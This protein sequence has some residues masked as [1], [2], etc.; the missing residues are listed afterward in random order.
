M[1]LF[2]YIPIQSSSDCVACQ[3]GKYT[4]NE[5]LSE[6]TNCEQG[7]YQ[8][9]QGSSGCDNC[10]KGYYQFALGARCVR[11]CLFICCICLCNSYRV[12]DGVLYVFACRC[13]R[14]VAF[15]TVCKLVRDLPMKYCSSCASCE[16]GKF[17]ANEGLANCTSCEAGRHQP[18]QASS[19]CINC[20]QGYYQFASGAR[21]VMSTRSSCVICL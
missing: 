5:G 15:I 17:T 21:Y 16:P 20:L 12:L 11:M 7:Q 1:Y 3:P 8:P 14:N 19:A 9:Q 2:I 6:C 18:S 10:P 4:A 13:V